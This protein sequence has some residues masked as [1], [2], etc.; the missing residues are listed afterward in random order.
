M[1]HH[2]QIPTDFATCRA[3]I[4]D[5]LPEIFYVETMSS[6]IGGKAVMKLTRAESR[7]HHKVTEDSPER[8]VSSVFLGKTSNQMI[9][10]YPRGR[11]L[12]RADEGQTLVEVSIQRRQAVFW[13]IRLIGW[14]CCLIPGVLLLILDSIAQAHWRKVLQRVAGRIRERY[15]EARMVER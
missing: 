11:V 6:A 12:G 4:A 3:F 7:S 14:A 15:P 13:T 10:A 9:H 1:A 2:I 8:V 5:E